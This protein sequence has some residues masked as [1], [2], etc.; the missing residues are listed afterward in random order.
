MN[1]TDISISRDGTTI[2]VGAPYESTNDFDGDYYVLRPKLG[3]A[4]VLQEESGQLAYTRGI[5][6]VQHD[7]ARFGYRVSLSADGQSLAVGTPYDKGEGLN[8][9]G[10]YQQVA[11]EY[12]L[13]W[14]STTT[15]PCGAAYLF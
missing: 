3:A 7:G 15:T 14:Y 5:K 9:S 12:I 10:E 2:A 4:Y 6:Q 13:P 8:E 1:G 11:P